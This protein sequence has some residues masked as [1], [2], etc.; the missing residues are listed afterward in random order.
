V[1]Q[2]PLFG[3]RKESAEH[4]RTTHGASF[5]RFW[6][7]WTG[8]TGWSGFSFFLSILSILFILSERIH[9][10]RTLRTY[11][12]LLRV[13]AFTEDWNEE[14]TLPEPSCRS[15]CLGPRGSGPADVAGG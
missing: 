10:G 6:T 9:P 13:L 15:N 4:A 5:S 8:F 14:A 7:G 11:V 12:I 1:P 2:L 3:R